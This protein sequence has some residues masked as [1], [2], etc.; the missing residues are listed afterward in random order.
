MTSQVGRWNSTTALLLL[1]LLNHLPE[2]VGVCLL[3][4]SGLSIRP[5]ARAVGD[6]RG[7]DTLCITQKQRQ[8]V[9]GLDVGPLCHPAVERGHSGRF[10]RPKAFYELVDDRIR[11]RVSNRWNVVALFVGSSVSGPHLL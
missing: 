4:V 2:G 10:G 3:A 8:G 7:P 11:L 6:P 5:G 9:F 1:G